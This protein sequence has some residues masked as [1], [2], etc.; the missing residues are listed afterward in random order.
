MWTIQATPKASTAP[1]E[2]MR[3]TM[4]CIRMFGNL[5]VLLLLASVI[6]AAE[7][8][9][10]AGKISY[11]RDIRPVLS[12]KCFFCHGPDPNKRKAKL[13]L[14]VREEALAK[15]AF[16]P[17]KPDE[18]ELIRRIFTTDLD[19]LMPPPESHKTLTSAEKQMFRRWIAQGAGYQ[20]H[21]AYVPPVKPSVP[22]NRNGIDFLVQERLKE[23]GL[24][25]SPEADRRTLARRLYFDL[26]GLPPRPEEV[27]PFEKDKSSDAYGK[28]VEKLLASPHY[29]E[30]MAIGWLDVVRFA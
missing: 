15:Q 13:R 24:K 26:I 1:G 30:R 18:S 17:G 12:D 8:A 2:V 4:A 21:W 7:A 5:T 27:A 16:I 14:D 6:S 25:P 29:G 19:D 20:K 23:L 11:N 9:P 22:P 3:L 10:S 28:L